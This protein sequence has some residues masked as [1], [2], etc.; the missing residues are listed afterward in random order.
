MLNSATMN[1]RTFLVGAAATAGVLATAGSFA[2]PRLAR[3]DEAQKGCTVKYYL[4]NPVAIEPFGAE[5]NQGVEVMSNTFDPLCTYDWNESKIVPLAAESYEANDDATQ[6]TF[7]LRKDGKFHN[8]DP[9]TSKDF[10]YAWE[11]LCKHDFKPAPSSIGYKLSQVKGADEMMAGTATELDVECPDDYTLVVNL[12][13]PFADFPSIV[14]EVALAPVPAGSTDT[15]ED[16]QKFRVAPIGNGPFQMDGEWVDGQYINLK[17]FADYWG[18]K[19]N[20]DGVNFAIYKDEDTAW[21]EFT[22]G[23]LDWT[24]IPSGQFQVALQ[25]YGE[26]DNDGYTAN[27]GKQVFSGEEC[28]I[29]YLLCNN[30]DDV[31]SNPDVRK[32]ISCAINRQAICD[33]VLQN[34]RTPAANMLVPGVPGYEEGAWDNCPAEGDKDK[35]GEYFDKAGYPLKDG[36]RGLNLTLSC[37][38]G[39]GHEDIMAMIQ[40]DLAQVG[41]TA[42]IQGQEW[43]AY[44][45]TVQAKQY[46]IGRMGWVIQVPYAD[47]ILQPLFYTGSGDNNF[48]Y[49]NEKFDKA[50]D[51]A[52]SI[53]DDDERIK[54][55]QDANKIVAE[56][57]PVIPMFFYRHTY[58]ASKRMHNMYLNPSTYCRLTDCWIEQ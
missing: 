50:I 55:Y 20:I 11:R 22:A 12:K 15:E 10:K 42:S 38:S 1:R 5:E 13:A 45:D 3:A 36:S 53:V 18:A 34:T 19:P 30:T 41:V 51:D 49:T 25:Q 16:F 48:A 37:N 6:F 29:Y 40:A 46:Q 24:A 58:I 57:F 27:P 9:V 17:P 31:M 23:N 47:G 8:G 21:T 4:T 54:A 7:H 32:A 56:D 2:S 44:V 33:S 14:A 26:A 43:A 35:A 39:A 28:S 52:R